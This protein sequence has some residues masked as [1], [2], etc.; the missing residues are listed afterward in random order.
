MSL[1]KY[2]E[3][4]KTIQDNIL[5]FL[6]NEED[7][8][9]NFEN[10]RQIFDEQKIFD[11]QQE[12]QSLMHLILKIANNYFRKSGFF[13][14]ICKILLLCK[15]TMKKYLSNSEIYQIFKDNN[16]I[17]LI[18]IEEK[19]MEFDDN[20]VK[21]LP[22][23]TMLYFLPEMQPFKYNKWFRRD[24]LRITNKFL[25]I[26]KKQEEEEIPEN[27]Y[28]DRKTGE[29]N[30]YICKLIQNDLID[31]FIT[32][33]NRNNYPIQSNIP[34]SFYDTNSFI[35]ECKITLIEYAAFFG[36]IQIFNYL[37]MNGANLNSFIWPYAIHG[38]NAELIQLL[39]ENNIEPYDK[40]YNECFIK[41]VIFFQK[42]IAN[43]F[44]DN[45]L[46]NFINKI[47]NMF[48]NNNIEQILESYNF[49]F[50][51]KKDINKN[52]F[53]ILCQNKY[54]KI[55]EILMKDKNFDVNA[56]QI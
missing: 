16:R 39:K 49:D 3:K 4:M 31:E 35:N 47:K 55:V 18:L 14:K 2:L 36:S 37:R 22:S 15:E 7:P 40:T 23:S 9:S 56:F 29:N 46:D 8:E 25:L 34:S 28:E 54:S 42:D 1:Q 5:E 44:M 33:V 43:Y 53:P 19:I 12:F 11:D 26:Y 13:D 24:N 27:L 6:D 10:L 17:L 52:T 20:I 45:Y 41:S 21:Q 50:I 51:E 32:Y 38:Q 48:Q 30:S